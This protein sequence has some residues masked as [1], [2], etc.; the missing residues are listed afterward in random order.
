M[1]D[2]RKEVERSLGDLRLAIE[3]LSNGLH[4]SIEVQATHTIMLR[5]ILEVATAPLEPE[6]GLADLCEQILM[7]LK[8]QTKVFAEMHRS[9]I[10]PFTESKSKADLGSR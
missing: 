5:A 3:R 1:I 2:N 9:F 6:Q 10:D 8:D 7:A 4:Q